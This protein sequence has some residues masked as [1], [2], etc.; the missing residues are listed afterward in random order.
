MTS[1]NTTWEAAVL[2][3]LREAPDPLHYTE[4]A[5]RILE[6]G[7]ETRTA[8]PQAIAN[9]TLRDLMS[10]RGGRRVQAID[11]QRGWYALAEKAQKFNSE[12]RDEEAAA[13]DSE[14]IKIAAF[15]LFWQRDLVNWDTGKTLYGQQSKDAIAVDFADQDGLYFLHDGRREVMYIGKTF[16][17]TA[18]YGLLTRLK[19]HH[20]DPRKTVYWDSF[21]WFGFK[22]VSEDGQLQQPPENATFKSVVSLIE[23]IFIETLLPRL[24]QQSG[25]G[26]AQAREDGLYFQSAAQR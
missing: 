17:P 7:F 25:E 11:N 15:G 26:M 3:V 23:A 24:N 18:R 8:N 14:I 22:P 12:I 16:T 9:K 13:D 19:S 1:R 10:A 4:I 6:R 2:E 20:D 5:Q 21:S